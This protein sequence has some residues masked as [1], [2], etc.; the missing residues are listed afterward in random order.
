MPALPLRGF[1]AV[2]VGG[3]RG[4]GAAVATLLAELGAGVV[5]NGRDADAVGATVGS[6]TAT[7]I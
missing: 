4:V 2:I 3:S 6:I 1:G 7:N 5:I